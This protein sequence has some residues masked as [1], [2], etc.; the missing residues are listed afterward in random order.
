VLGYGLVGHAISLRLAL[1]R[2]AS[3]TAY[4]VNDE[5]TNG[6]A[7]TGVAVAKTAE[8]LLRAVDIAFVCVYSGA[9]V[10][11]C[12]EIAGSLDEAQRPLLAALTT[13]TPT[14]ESDIRSLARALDVAVAFAP[15]S[16]TSSQLA[17]GQ[18]LAI[19][20]RRSAELL[21]RWLSDLSEA[22]G[23]HCVIDGPGTAA[24]AKLA[25]NLV[26]EGNRA[27]LAEGL[28]FASLGGISPSQ[29]LSLLTRSAGASTVARD[30]GPKMVARD[31]TPE[32]FLRQSA[33]DLAFVLEIAD[34]AGQPLP[35]TCAVAQLN[36]A[37]VAG[38]LGELDSSALIQELESMSRGRDD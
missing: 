3:L 31:F 2:K 25:L 10:A 6:A 15:V 20:N 1:N 16:G 14:Q 33:K 29:Y 9:Q 34:R 24:H 28:R 32:S 13:L 22:V 21:G 5:R 27:V 36:D 30:K 11:E 7:T 37:A 19:V 23:D 35:T 18:G 38:G 8:D 12:V 4:D 17:N 26:V